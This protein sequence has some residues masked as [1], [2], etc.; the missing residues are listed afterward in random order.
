VG[1]QLRRS[2]N[3]TGSKDVSYETSSNV[4]FCK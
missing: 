3:H 4:N 1:H 2:E